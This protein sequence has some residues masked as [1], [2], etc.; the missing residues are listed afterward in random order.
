M[1][2]TACVI[3]GRGEGRK[4]GF[5]T[6]NLEIPDGLAAKQGVYAGWVWLT[7]DGDKRQPAAFHYGPTPAFGIEKF[8]LEAH[9]I[10]QE[11]PSPPPELSFELVKYLRPVLDF[12]ALEGLAAQIREDVRQAREALRIV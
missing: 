5:P 1:K 10:D 9:V 12:E 6:L 11:I 7:R 2:Y 3:P 4:L 8:S